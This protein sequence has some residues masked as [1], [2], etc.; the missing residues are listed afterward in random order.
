MMKKYLFIA[1][2]ITAMLSG[3]KKNDWLDWKVQNEMWLEQN[4]LDYANDTTFHISSTGLQY[5]II[6][7]GNTSDAKPSSYSSVICHY[8]GRLINGH[9]FDGGVGSFYISDL[10][11][12][13]REGL[14]KIH[15][16]GDIELYI[17]YTLGYSKEAGYE[18]DGTGT[19]GTSA[20]IPPYSTLIFRVHLDAIQ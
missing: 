11:P 5:R 12:G 10:I 8:E 17:P 4:K 14:R 15:C 6:Y 7:P 9:K 18:E 20:Y 1:L 2:A 3:C 16:H 13:F 19:E